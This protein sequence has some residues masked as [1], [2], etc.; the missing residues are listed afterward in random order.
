MPS[1]PLP[2]PTGPQDD[3]VLRLA[4]QIA[5][6]EA[7]PGVSEPPVER[8]HFDQ[9]RARALAR[10]AGLRR[11]IR[12]G[13]GLLALSAL[14]LALGLGYASLTPEPVVVKAWVEVRGQPGA[15]LTA[16]R[17]A[18]GLRLVVEVAHLE[19]DVVVGLEARWLDPAGAER[20][21]CADSR[22]HLR[23]RTLT[24]A[25]EVPLEPPVPAGRWQVEVR[26]SQPDRHGHLPLI[27]GAE[28]RGVLPFAIN[29]Q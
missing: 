6:D 17:A 2:P 8:R 18:E 25:C 22:H 14:G 1:D 3:D 20:G 26:V 9:A 16:A 13:S 11:W 19:S 24:L 7:G 23:T 12:L 21:W 10:E 5:R 15:A 27:R 29:A 4:L 28:E